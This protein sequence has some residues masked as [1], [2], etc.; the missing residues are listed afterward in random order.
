M[1][2]LKLLKVQGLYSHEYGERIV[3]EYIMTATLKLCACYKWQHFIVVAKFC[4]M[5][6]IMRLSRVKY[7]FVSVHMFV[8][9]FHNDPN[10]IVQ[11]VKLKKY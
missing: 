2:I 1:Y 10:V 9:S 11:V 5:E 6:H 3:I 8:I 4:L 7:Y